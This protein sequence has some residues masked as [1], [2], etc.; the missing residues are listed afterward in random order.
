[1][2]LQSIE[3]RIAEARPAW[4]KE[5]WMDDDGLT[6]ARMDGWMDGWMDEWTDGWIDGWMDGW[7]DGRTDDWM[8]RWMH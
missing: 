6:Y 5:G 3:T 8:E 1:M 2:L 4:R 7:M